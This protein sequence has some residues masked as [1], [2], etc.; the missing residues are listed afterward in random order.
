MNYRIVQSRLNP[1]NRTSRDQQG[2]TGDQSP[3]LSDILHISAILLKLSDVART[4]K[5]GKFVKALRG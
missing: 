5:K 1:V 4:E 3:I 2:R